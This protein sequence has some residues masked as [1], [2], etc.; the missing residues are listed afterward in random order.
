[1]T[2]NWCTLQSLKDNYLIEFPPY[3][4]SFLLQFCNLLLPYDMTVVHV[5]DSICNG[6]KVVTWKGHVISVE[7]RHWLLLEIIPLELSRLICWKTVWQKWMC[8]NMLNFVRTI[9][10]TKMEVIDTG[11]VNDDTCR[12]MICFPDT[13]YFCTDSTRVLKKRF[14]L[15]QI[16]WSQHWVN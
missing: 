13:V 11:F 5:A 8:V 6:S 1:M 14:Q 15:S 16:I 4:R 9:N 12:S 3:T 7:E 10:Q 2:S